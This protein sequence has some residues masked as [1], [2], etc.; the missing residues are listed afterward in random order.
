MCGSLDERFRPG[1]ALLYT[2]IED[3][4]GIPLATDKDLTAAIQHA[5]PNALTGIRALS[6]GHIVTRASE[7]RALAQRWG[8]HVCDMES[9]ALLARLHRAGAS[10][11]IL[12]VVSDG[13]DDNLPD[14][15]AAVDAAGNLDGKALARA[16]L[17]SPLAALRMTLGA[18]TA[19]R[20]L[21]RSVPFGRDDV[22]A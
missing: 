6:V 11:A 16:S 12:R 17:L 2:S 19:L 14:L 15:N 5:V 4:D 10:V 8:C 22:R 18:T 1:D 3:T 9:L 7:K 21:R 20:V 13:V